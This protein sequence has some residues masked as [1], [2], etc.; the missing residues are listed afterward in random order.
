MMNCCWQAR[1]LPVAP[2][3]FFF[4][5]EERLSWH[6]SPDFYRQMVWPDQVSLKYNKKIIKTMLQSQQ[7]YYYWFGWA[8]KVLRF[9]CL[10]MLHDG[11]TSADC[12]LS[13][14][15]KLI[16]ILVNTSA[17]ALSSLT[18][19]CC[20]SRFKVPAAI[21]CEA[22]RHKYRACYSFQERCF[23]SNVQ[24]RVTTRA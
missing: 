10:H 5:M 22:S 13:I 18:K 19:N 9:P 4:L 15:A 11:K 8:Q 21:F 24:R 20:R 7:S 3:D 2:R 23:G 14:G 17:R 1:G 16:I 12:L 6:F